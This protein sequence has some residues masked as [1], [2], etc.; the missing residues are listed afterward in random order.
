M[1]DR[2]IRMNGVTDIRGA[3][4]YANVLNALYAAARCAR[5]RRA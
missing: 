2:S 5:A 3:C 4:N 1:L